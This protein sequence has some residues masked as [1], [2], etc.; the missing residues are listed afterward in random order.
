MLADEGWLLFHSISIIRICLSASSRVDHLPL[1][2]PFR[3][4]DRRRVGCHGPR[5]RPYDGGSRDG[6][7]L[8]SDLRHPQGLPALQDVR[9]GVI[10]VRSGLDGVLRDGTVGSRRD[11]PIRKIDG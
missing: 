4:H 3:K 7:G 9:V 1:R 2:P 8:R 6:P 5:R 10:L 11:I